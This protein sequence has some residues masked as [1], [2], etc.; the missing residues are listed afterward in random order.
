[1][2]QNNVLRLGPAVRGGFGEV[3]SE[4][5]IVVL[6]LVLLEGEEKECFLRFL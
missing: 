6:D 2:V 4:D 3:D 1:M 5:D